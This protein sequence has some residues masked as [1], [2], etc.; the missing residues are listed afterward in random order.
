MNDGM[1]RFTCMPGGPRYGLVGQL[2]M[3]WPNRRMSSQHSTGQRVPQRG[4]ETVEID[5]GHGSQG[6]GEV[7]GCGA[8]RPRFG[9]VARFWQHCQLLATLPTF[10]HLAGV[11]AIWQ[12]PGKVASFWQRCH[13]LTDRAGEC[14]TRRFRGSLRSYYPG[15][16]LPSPP[17]H[18]LSSRLRQFLP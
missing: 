10:G 16:R 2:E 18:F 1:P 4:R 13:R 14:K 17:E 8:R 6:R 7:P 12:P 15:S 5:P 3:S 11:A 9:N